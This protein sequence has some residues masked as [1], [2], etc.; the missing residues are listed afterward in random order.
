MSDP[1]FTARTGRG[2]PRRP[3]TGEII[4]GAPRKPYQRKIRPGSAEAFAG[5]LQKISSDIPDPREVRR[6]FGVQETALRPAAWIGPAMLLCGVAYMF[7]IS[8]PVAS[9]VLTFTL[10]ALA[11]LSILPR[12]QA[13]QSQD[14]LPG[15]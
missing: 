4:F 5:G 9:V 2:H 14:C 7:C 15:S 6:F 3:V 1:T 11:I 8:W 12:G 13:I 10:A